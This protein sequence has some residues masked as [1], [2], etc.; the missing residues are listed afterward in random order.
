MLLT[1]KTHLI[2]LLVP[3]AVQASVGDK[4]P[5]YQKCVVECES[6]VCAAKSPSPKYSSNSVNP[7]SRVLFGW[8]CYLDCGY[9]C[10]QLVTSERLS[11]GEEVVQFFGKWPFV[12]VW[13][14]TE[15]FST[16]FSIGNFYVNY[17]NYLKL[18]QILR[19]N[20]NNPDKLIIYRQ[21]QILVLVNM[22]GWVCSSAFHI[23]DTSLT[24]TL[25]YLGAGAIVMAN[26][27]A[28][29][30]RYF[31]LH[32]TKNRGR[33][34]SFQYALIFL[35]SLHYIRLY[36][37][38]D[39]DYNMTFNVILGLVA[40]GFWIAHSYLV[41]RKCQKGSVAS[42]SVHLAPYE[43]KITSKLKAIGIHETSWFPLIPVVLNL[44]L[45]LAVSLELLDFVPW[46]LLIDAHSL[47]HMCTILPPIIWHDWNIWELELSTMDSRL[48]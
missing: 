37:S 41:Y 16:L 21:F 8:D 14:I 15:V 38:W 10:Q 3:L 30:V 43:E 42:K 44:Y 9:K 35:L 31:D 20:A 40:A 26:F 36:I 28:V 17:H 47:W 23:R 11:H 39:Y 45:I 1:W 46:F 25:D 18:K 5:E 7:I 6:L 12:R 19:I 27:N 34:Q 32:L 48:P 29:F 22:F 2:L 4:L 13:G 33:L 24:E